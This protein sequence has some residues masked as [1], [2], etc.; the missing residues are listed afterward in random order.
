[1][2]FVSIGSKKMARAKSPFGVMRENACFVH[3]QP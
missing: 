3:S 1:M 2:N